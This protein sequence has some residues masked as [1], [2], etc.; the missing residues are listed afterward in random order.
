MNYAKRS[1]ELALELNDKL[2]N[3]ENISRSYACK[4]YLHY[5]YG[6]DEIKSSIVWLEEVELIADKTG[7]IKLSLFCNKILIDAYDKIH[8]KDKANRLRSKLN[9]KLKGT[10]INIEK[11]FVMDIWPMGYAFDFIKKS[12]DW[13]LSARISHSIP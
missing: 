3:K 13:N 1:I 4:A 11:L 8:N 9:I 2:D 5:L 7:D 12:S 6:N 10:N